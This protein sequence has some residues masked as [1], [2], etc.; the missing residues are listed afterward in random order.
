[1]SQQRDKDTAATAAKAAVEA[2]GPST[3]VILRVIM[4]LLVVGVV[5]WILTKITGILLLLVLSIF[6]AYLVAPLVELASH[7]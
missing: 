3:R 1:V 5:L 2:Y 4:V 7:T 6:F